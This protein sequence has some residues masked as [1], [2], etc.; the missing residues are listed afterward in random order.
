MIRIKGFRK[1]FCKYSF[2][3]GKTVPAILVMGEKKAFQNLRTFQRWPSIFCTP[4]LT[5]FVG[6]K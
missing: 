2:V 5:S 1:T 4:S 6:K 3:K